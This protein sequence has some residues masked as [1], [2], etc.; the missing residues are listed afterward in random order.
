MRFY[1]IKTPIYYLYNNAN[2]KRNHTVIEED[3]LN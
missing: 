3:R 1:N 2:K